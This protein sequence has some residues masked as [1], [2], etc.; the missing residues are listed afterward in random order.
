MNSKEISVPQNAKNMMRHSLN[1]KNIIP[2]C[3]MLNAE[4][5]MMITAGS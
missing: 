5:K 1:V 3:S 4:L 2:V